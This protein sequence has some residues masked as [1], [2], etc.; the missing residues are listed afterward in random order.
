MMSATK[1]RVKKEMIDSVINNSSPVRGKRPNI[2]WIV[3]DHVTFRH[4][5]MTQ[6]A[7]PLLNTYERLAS[8]GMEFTNCHS[9]H[10][11]CL[12][13]RATMM[14]GVYT[15]KHGKIDNSQYPDAGYPLFGEYLK[16]LGYRMG[17][18]GKN[19]SGYE[20]LSARGIEGFYPF[21]YGN[22]YRTKEY[23]EYL[24]KKGLSHPIFH[25]EWGIITFPRD[26]YLYQNGDYDLT[27][28]N[29]F[30]TYSA[31]YLKTPGPV[32]E[33]DFITSMA[34]DWMIEHRNENNP[35]VLQ[36]DLWGPH[37][38]FQVP[39]EYKDVIN[40][41]EIAE[42]PS[43]RD[44]MKHRP[45]FVQE[46]LQGIRNR[47][48]ISTWPEWQLV[49]KRAYEQYSYIDAAVGRLLDWLEQDGLADNTIVIYTADHG[50][51]LG[52]HGGMVDKAGDMME[53]LMQIPLVIRWPGI[54]NGVSSDALV[55]NL[56]LVPTVLDLAGAK[57]PEYI[58]GRSLTPLLKGMNTD[59]REDLM[60]Q[61]YGH[62]AV[63]L[64]Q[65]ALYYQN[66]KYIAVDGDMDELYDLQKDPFELENL[67]NDP[68]SQ[69]VARMMRR[70]LLA[71]M[72]RHG[73][74]GEDV[75]ALREAIK[76][77]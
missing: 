10:P 75:K 39:L 29:N 55:S 15:H 5:K 32:H 1:P 17:Y 16:Q 14:T 20:D 13:A 67:V 63:R 51:A 23:Q 21:D 27:E 58:D 4:F 36:V 72:D 33:A 60:A 48:P 25:Q 28:S 76:D 71:K 24:D 11:L 35:F 56:D 37:H 57:L 42:Y 8:Q 40:P 64:A 18:F 74:A 69:E 34:M 30:N 65:R 12:P 77:R 3:L 41:E 31:G 22:P 66:F 54:T 47:N 59:W 19:H 62:F 7:K 38:S 61:H 2:L 43:F 45:Q 26:G 73:D 68:A 46:F 9:T 49:I 70:R 52:S 53:E 50:D 44:E 6:G